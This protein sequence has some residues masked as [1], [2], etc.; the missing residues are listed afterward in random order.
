MIKRMTS[1]KFLPAI[2]FF[3]FATLSTILIL[4]CA[5]PIPILYFPD[6]QHRMQA[7]RHWDLLAKDVAEQ[8]KLTLDNARIISEQRIYVV[9]NDTTPFGKTF[10][11]LLITQLVKVGLPVC[12]EKR[13]SALMVENSVQVIRHRAQRMVDDMWGSNSI[14]TVLSD[15]ILVLRGNDETT[16]GPTQFTVENVANGLPHTEV[17]ITSTIINNND[18]VL[19]R[20]DIYYINDPDFWHYQNLPPYD[21]AGKDIKEFPIKG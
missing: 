8:I 14:Y 15:D 19:R 10:R 3:T 16:V 6:T 9:P 5:S 11:E 18:Y 17:V 7:V 1:T 12:H 2:I 21:P 20:S 4:G 13:D